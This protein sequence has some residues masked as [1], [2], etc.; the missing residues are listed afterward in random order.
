MNLYGLNLK[1]LT[2][3]FKL[4]KLTTLILSFNKLTSI[5]ALT[6]CPNLTK[7][8]LSY[9]LL[10]SVDYITDLKKLEVLYLHFNQIDDI[11]LLED[12]QYLIKLREL[13]IRGNPL[14]SEH[15]YRT[16]IIQMFNEQLQILDCVKITKGDLVN[17][18]LNFQKITDELI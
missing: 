11:K 9:N 8:D 5:R 12:L 1:S 4:E 16:L 13:H 18:S 3:D 2:I 10:N 17:K 14:E 6:N 7:L 15:G